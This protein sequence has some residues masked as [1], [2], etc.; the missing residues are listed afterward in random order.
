M[1]KNRDRD[2]GADFESYVARLY[3]SLGFKI[4]TNVNLGGQQIDVLAETHIPGIGRAQLIVECKWREGRSISNQEVFD[5]LNIIKS[6]QPKYNITRGVLVSNSGFSQDAMRIGLDNTEAIELLTITDL[7]NQLFDL[8]RT[9]TAFVQDYESRHIF[10]S[11]VPLRA[12]YHT[13]G[14]EA[15]QT[16]AEDIEAILEDWLTSPGI[17]Y[18]SV[19]ADYG[20][21]KTTLLQRIKYKL[22]KLCLTNNRTA[23]PFFVP[24]RKF[25]NYDSLDSFLRAVIVMEFEREIPLAV[26]WRAVNEGGLVILLDGFDEVVSESDRDNRRDSFLQLFP[27][28]GRGSKV[29]LTCRPSYFIS[30]RE[31]EEL[32]SIVN[33]RDSPARIAF[34][35]SFRPSGDEM[36]KA[37]GLKTVLLSKLGEYNP[38]TRVRA[39]SIKVVNLE[40]FEEGQIDSYLKRFDREYRERCSVSWQEVKNFLI[41]IY[42]L[43]DLM[44]RPIL[45]A[46]INETVLNGGI[47]INSEIGSFGPSTLYEVYTTFKLDTDWLKGSTR[48]LIPKEHRAALAEAVA[49]GMFE[50]GSLEISYED[51]FRFA[52]RK[53]AFEKEVIDGLKGLST[54]AITAD[55]QVCT[56]LTRSGEGVFRFSHRSFVEFF[57]ARHLKRMAV[58]YNK[59]PLLLINTYLP[60]EIL[61]FLGGFAMLE[62]GLRD[63]LLR[64][65]SEGVP[66][67]AQFTSN[68]VGALLYSGPVQENLQLSNTEILRIDIR[69]VKF[70]S[71]VWRRL[72]FVNVGWKDLFFHQPD[73]LNLSVKDSELHDVS[74]KGG[75]IDYALSDVLIKNFIVSDVQLR[76]RSRSSH[77]DMGRLIASRI[78]VSGKLRITRCSFFESTIEM[79]ESLEEVNFRNCEFHDTIIK[80]PKD[81][82]AKNID[83]RGCRF[84]RCYFLGMVVT[85]AQYAK[86][87]L[88]NCRGFLFGDGLWED[89]RFDPSCPIANIDD[90]AGLIIVKNDS[91][92]ND[93]VRKEIVSRWGELSRQPAADL[94]EY[95]LT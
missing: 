49:V 70:I 22:A 20:A 72:K 58:L 75:L 25:H 14:N 39:T 56:F 5:F 1:D 59:K 87:A 11:Y 23:K 32:I 74:I 63:R 26:F 60:R 17:D 44:T 9:F 81:G 30:S 15:G 50:R 86:L 79:G 65:Y 13:P 68:I 84:E 69:K 31:H 51:L 7:E 43:R 46:M 41:G 28:I 24:L 6:L 4:D 18:V 67:G 3:E 80:F 57:V 82:T 35:D 62:P 77:L 53:S 2:K 21:G 47:A 36:T 95:L 19:L 27:L 12:R 42:D 91:W 85:E 16:F 55:L 66:H 52:E 76:V 54:A 73:I 93:M 71:P 88:S 37:M 38:I 61:Y 64:W 40:L 33:S 10:T 94:S 34:D 89:M 83:V 29:I 92:T 48:R 8:R 90:Q 78:T 45:L